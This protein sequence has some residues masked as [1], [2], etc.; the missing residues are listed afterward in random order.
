MYVNELL[1]ALFWRDLAE[2]REFYAAL[3]RRYFPDGA[4]QPTNADAYARELDAWLK[5][6]IP[7]PDVFYARVDDY[8]A[9]AKPLWQADR[10]HSCA[11]LPADELRSAIHRGTATHGREL[12]RRFSDTHWADIHFAQYVPAVTERADANI[13]ELATG[14]GHGTYAVMRAL[15]RNSIFISVDVDFAAAR[16]AN[17]LAAALELSDRACGLNANFWYLPFGNGSIDVVCSHYGLD[18]S[19]EIQR[20]LAE[21]AR[22]LKRGGWFVN[23]GREHPEARH[24][25]YFALFGASIEQHREVAKKLR[26]YSGFDDLNELAQTVA[27]KLVSYDVIVPQDSHSRIVAVWEKM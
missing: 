20:T 12:I 13:L 9:N 17:A 3:T 19:G 27:L 14:A 7:S 4:A 24:S 25:K 21:V 1:H 5:G 15:E 16:N 23:V 22:V 2:L 6:K 8:A 26:L 10:A 18:E 11:E